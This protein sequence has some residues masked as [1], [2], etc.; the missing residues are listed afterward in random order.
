[1]TKWLWGLETVTCNLQAP[2]AIEEHPMPSY[3]LRRSPK[4]RN[5]GENQQRSWSQDY[6]RTDGSVGNMESSMKGETRGKEDRYE[7]ALSFLSK[8]RHQKGQSSQ[9]I[10]LQVMIKTAFV[11]ASAGMPLGG[12][13]ICFCMSAEQSNGGDFFW[14]LTGTF[15]FPQTSPLWRVSQAIFDK[16]VSSLTISAVTSV[17]IFDIVPPTI[18]NLPSTALG[19]DPCPKMEIIFRSERFLLKESYVLGLF[20]N[21]ILG[22]CSAGERCYRWVYTNIIHWLA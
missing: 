22:L 15:L 4:H 6:G 19:P 5:W 17:H 11:S 2:N 13:R 1:M 10:V 16:G 20:Q 18:F 12:W 14:V 8:P 9:I 3:L 21:I 7:T